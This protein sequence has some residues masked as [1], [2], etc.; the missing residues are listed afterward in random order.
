[1]LQ[2]D[3][4]GAVHAHEAA[5]REPVLQRLEAHQHDQRGRGIRQPDLGVLAHPLDITDI[6]YAHAHGPVV[7][8]EEERVVLRRDGRRGRRSRGLAR[9]QALPQ[10]LRRRQEIRQSEG[11][12]Q[13][14][15][16]I[17]PETFHRKLG[18][19]GRE[20]HQGRVGER[21]HEIHPGDV[22]HVDIQEHRIHR[23]LAEHA[24]C[25]H[26]AVAGRHQFQ[27]G[28]LGD[29]HFQLLER[30]RLIVYGQDSDHRASGISGCAGKTR[31]SS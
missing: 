17:D 4:I 16:G 2:A 14:V 24:P 1:M 7:R 15:Y 3:D 25:L 23:L 5:R 22:R 31:S 11:L 6:P 26:G 28:N 19:R 8:L 12:E 13:V 29:I 10:F 21:T 30:Q 20:Y 18:V 27:V 9:S